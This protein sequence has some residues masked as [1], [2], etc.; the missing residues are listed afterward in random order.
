MGNKH[1]GD[2][3]NTFLPKRRLA[4]DRSLRTASF[5]FFEKVTWVNSRIPGTGK[6]IIFPDTCGGPGQWFYISAGGP[7]RKT[8]FEF[9]PFY[10]DACAAGGRYQYLDRWCQYSVS[11]IISTQ[12]DA[13]GLRKSSLLILNA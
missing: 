3:R 13:P 12:T 9:Y 1:F 11:E 8:L 5:I 10:A 4:Y 7:S 6:C 2:G